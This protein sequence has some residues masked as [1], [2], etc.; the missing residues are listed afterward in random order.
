ML[1]PEAELHEIFEFVDA[2]HDTNKYTILEFLSEGKKHFLVPKTITALDA[3]QVSLEISLMN[4]LKES[5]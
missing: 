4:T 5:S 2:L 3:L 1:L